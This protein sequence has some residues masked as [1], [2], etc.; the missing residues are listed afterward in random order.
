MGQAKARK[1]AN[2][3][4]FVQ[5]DQELKIYGIDTSKFGFYDQEHFLEQEATNSDF[6]ENYAEWVILRPIEKEYVEHVKV[7]VPQLVELVHS[8]FVEYGLDG[9]CVAASGMITRMLDRLGVWS[10]AVA[11]SLTLEVE[12]TGLPL[13][14]R[15]K[16]VV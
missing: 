11:G 13:I 15:W 5:L 12:K 6:L 9:G 4:R 2:A 1:T 7:V 10:F 16:S 3:G 14:I 8:E